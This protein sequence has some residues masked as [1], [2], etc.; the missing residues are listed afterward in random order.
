MV[1][2]DCTMQTGSSFAH[3]LNR[4]WSTYC[5]PGP[6]YT[7]VTTQAQSQSH[8]APRLMA[9]QWAR[10]KIHGNVKQSRDGDGVGGP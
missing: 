3:S 10:K 4:V 2:T 7:A 9:R 5:V 1:R 8:A 6:E